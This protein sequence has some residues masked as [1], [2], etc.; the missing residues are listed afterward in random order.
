MRYLVTNTG[1]EILGLGQPY[2]D[3]A[4]AENARL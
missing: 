2:R 4:D 3:R 1:Y